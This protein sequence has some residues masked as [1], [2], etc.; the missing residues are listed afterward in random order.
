MKAV[1]VA[2]KRPACQLINAPPSYNIIIAYKNDDALHVI[3]PA[4]D[5]CL[6]IFL[7][8]RDIHGPYF[9]TGGFCARVKGYEE[10]MNQ[11]KAVG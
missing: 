4:F 10:H 9:G 2:E 7:C 1:K 8:L 6:V 11:L 3:L 5:E